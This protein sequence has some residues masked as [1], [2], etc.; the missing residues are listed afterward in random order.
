MSSTTLEKPLFSFSDFEKGLML[1]GFIPPAND[2]EL[3]ERENLEVF[4]KQKKKT[5][6]N[7]YFKRA[8]LAAEIASELHEEPTFGRI[9]FQKLVYL[10]EHA[11]NMRLQD[12]YKKQAAGPFDNKFMHSIEQEFK[13]Q[14]WFSVEK[15]KEANFNRSKYIMLDGC[16]KYKKYFDSYF[17]GISEQITHV[18]TLFRK[19]KTDKTEIAATLFA[20]SIELQSKGELISEEKLLKLFYAWSERKAQYDKKIVL[21]TWEWMKETDLI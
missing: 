2:A 10:C 1:A 21:S 7:L 4:E 16:S 13:K 19:A 20:C 8:V 15:I 17:G 9:K 11:A 3:Q 5:K 12:R 18:I 14:N 6:S